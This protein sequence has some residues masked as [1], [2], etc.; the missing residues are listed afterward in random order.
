MPYFTKDPKRDHNFDNH[1]MAIL[2]SQ[3][4][5]Y[6]TLC[7]Q[8][9]RPHGKAGISCAKIH[10]KLG[11]YKEV[12]GS[13]SRHRRIKELGLSLQDSHVLDVVVPEDQAVG[14]GLMCGSL[15]HRASLASWGAGL[16]SLRISSQFIV[17]GCLTLGTKDVPELIYM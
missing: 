17:C 7:E 1:P 14:C 12:C 5:V 11:Q 9:G 4:K 2:Q 16:A 15:R 6:C 8:K 3:D 10:A 13:D